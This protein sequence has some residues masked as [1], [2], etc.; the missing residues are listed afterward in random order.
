MSR[1]SI[2]TDNVRNSSKIIESIATSLNAQERQ[3]NSCRNTLRKISSITQLADSVTTCIENTKDCKRKSLILAQTINAIAIRYDSAENAIIENQASHSSGEYLTPS[4]GGHG[5]GGSVVS[6]TD[7]SQ[8]QQTQ[9]WLDNAS[10]AEYAALCGWCNEAAEKGSEEE[11][12]HLFYEKLQT[13]PDNDPLKHIPEDKIVAYKYKSGMEVI[14]FELD[15]DHAV[16]IFAGTDSFSDG[17]TDADL[18]LFGNAGFQDNDANQLIRDMNYKDV[19]VMGHSLGGYLAAD[20]TLNNDKVS[21]CVTFDAPGHKLKYVGSQA[22]KDHLG[23]DPTDPFKLKVVVNK[24]ASKVQN[25]RAKG[26]A[27]SEVNEQVGVNVTSL[28]VENNWAG[29]FHNH[30]IGEIKDATGGDALISATYDNPELLQEY[31]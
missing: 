29:A 8:E 13:L 18:S 25:Y 16:V 1:F 10:G 6:I 23:F 9:L 26:S 12:R 27:V 24:N 19:T 11:M 20:V 15:P 31:M 28:D 17:A 3:L 30:G 21:K 2:D 4:G 7:L 22:D 14:V 5:A